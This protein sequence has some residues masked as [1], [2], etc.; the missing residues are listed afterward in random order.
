MIYRAQ[1]PECD[2]DIKLTNISCSKCRNHPPPGQKVAGHQR[3]GQKVAGHQRPG[4]KV[5]GQQRPGQKVAGQQ[6]PDRTFQPLLGSLPQTFPKPSAI[7]LK[8]QISMSSIQAWSL[9]RLELPMMRRAQSTRGCTRPERT[10]S[11]ITLY[12]L[13]WDASPKPSQ[14]L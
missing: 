5:A 4:Q 8:L 7:G 9:F 10:S 11:Q 1:S 12:S 13:F 14:N 3:P 6:R 2:C